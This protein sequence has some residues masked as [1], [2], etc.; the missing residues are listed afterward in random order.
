MS[1]VPSLVL[2]REGPAERLLIMRVGDVNPQRINGGV[3]L[4][5]VVT[6]V[7]DAGA[8]HVSHVHLE[9]VFVAHHLAALWALHLIHRHI[10]PGAPPVVP[11]RPPGSQILQGGFAESARFRIAVRLLEKEAQ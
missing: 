11:P 10:S 8:V 5:A 9:Y 3:G 1:I 6:L 4:G 2:R 7:H